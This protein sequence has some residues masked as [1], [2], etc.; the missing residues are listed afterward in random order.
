WLG[1]Y[2]NLRLS[3]KKY[4]RIIKGK[5]LKAANFLK[6]LNKIQKGSPPDVVAIVAKAC[7]APVALYRTEAF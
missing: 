1:I 6:S 2:L 3:F 5:A 4:L 7:V